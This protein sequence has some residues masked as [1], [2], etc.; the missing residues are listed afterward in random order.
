ME[1]LA[2][3][4][5]EGYK[6]AKAAIEDLAEN[7]VDNED[8]YDKACA[9]L[10]RGDYETLDEV[11]SMVTGELLVAFVIPCYSVDVCYY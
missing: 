3:T 10:K 5:V 2:N 4:L 8:L 6:K 9:A 11:I 7:L 1:E